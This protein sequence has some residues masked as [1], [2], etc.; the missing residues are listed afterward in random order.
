MAK[1]WLVLKDSISNS[2]Y[3]LRNGLSAI[4]G[5]AILGSVLNFG[6]QVLLSRFLTNEEF[7]ELGSI[8]AQAILLSTIG[9]AGVYGVWLQTFPKSRR[10]SD[11]IGPGIR[12]SAGSS[13]CLW[14][15]FAVFGGL[16]GGWHGFVL[17]L[18]IGSELVNRA[19]IELNSGACQVGGHHLRY[20]LY[21][22]WPSVVRLTIIIAAQ[23]FAAGTGGS[24]LLTFAWF[25]LL[26]SGIIVVV[27]IHGLRS[28]WSTQVAQDGDEPLE[29]VSSAKVLELGWPF[30]ANALLLAS[31]GQLPIII[32]A[33]M[34]SNSDAS[35][36]LVANTLVMAGYL[37][38]GLI[39]RR[40]FQPL[41]FHAVESDLKRY[42]RFVTKGYWHSVVLGMILALTVALG[43]AP[44]VDSIFGQSYGESIRLI[45]I[46]SISVF[47]R[48][49][50]NHSG[51]ALVRKDDI[52][53]RAK[54]QFYVLLGIAPGMFLASSQFGLTGLVW[55]III[56]DG[57]LAGVL[58]YRARYAVARELAAKS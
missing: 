18:L 7:G 28:F 45:Q 1:H 5:F 23:Y 47:F 8:L 57:F 17:F 19:A 55:C 6:S 50:I 58:Y 43:A 56:S 13:F 27:C 42:A 10:K 2:S 33:Y 46:L 32:A 22:A 21:Q 4:A 20:A 35:Y 38:V 48:S 29:T 54:I 30:V 9:G 16:Q 36:F 3:H 11:W 37:V 51:T 15:L 34:I 39:Y 40:Y 44:L 31:S 52:V 26:F 14:V 53:F 12:L 41:M 25:H 49:L 24:N